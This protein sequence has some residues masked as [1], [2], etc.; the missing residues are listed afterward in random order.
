MDSL[1][2][3]LHKIQSQYFPRWDIN[4]KYRIEKWDLS[5]ARCDYKRKLINVSDVNDELVIIHEICHAV[6]VKGLH[7]P[8]FQN[9][10]L[11]VAAV[12]DSLGKPK[13]AKDIRD[14]V[15]WIRNQFKEHPERRLT[16]REVCDEIQDAVL[17]IPKLSFEDIVKLVAREHAMYP[18]E[19]LKDYPKSLRRAFDSAHS[20]IEANRDLNQ[21]LGI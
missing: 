4:H 13:L 19:L 1:T 6:V 3:R 7:G 15:D 2:K 9:R 21:K 10:L 18:E 12:A 17:D 11:K 20:L 5:G 8:A 16:A 14:E